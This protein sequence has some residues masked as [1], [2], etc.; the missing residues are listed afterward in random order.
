MLPHLSFV[1]CICIYVYTIMYVFLSSQSGFN[2]NL[3]VGLSISLV[4][5]L[6]T[7]SGLI[8]CLVCAL[9]VWRR[10]SQQGG[11]TWCSYFTTRNPPA[12]F[13]TARFT[14]ENN[15]QDV[16]IKTNI[17]RGGPLGKDDTPPPPYPT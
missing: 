17:T 15:Y 8:S 16:T 5:L 1:L 3:V 14:Q 13:T 7:I 6:G 10:R 12:S 11:C 4:L 9:C 2:L